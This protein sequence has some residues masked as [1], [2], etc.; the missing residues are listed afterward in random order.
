VP[1]INPLM[2][3]M[4]T[5]SET[6]TIVF[7]VPMMLRMTSMLGRLKAGPASNRARAGPWPMPAPNNPCRMG[8][9]VRVAKYMSAPATEANRLA[10]R[11]LPP[12]A[13]ATQA[14]GIS[15]S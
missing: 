2:V 3:A 1:K 7:C 13:P 14:L 8:T 4:T 15:P 5:T 11:E 10:Q 9:S 12:T 6:K